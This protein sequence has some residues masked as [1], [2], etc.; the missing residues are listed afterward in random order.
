MAPAWI[1]RREIMELSLILS[2]CGN[3][4]GAACAPLSCVFN[5]LPT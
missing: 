3:L 5:A 2:H 1:N 4:H